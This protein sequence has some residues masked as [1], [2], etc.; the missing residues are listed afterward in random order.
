MKLGDIYISKT[1]KDIIQIDSFATP[2]NDEGDMYIIIACIFNNGGIYGSSPSFNQYATQKEIEDR[3]ELLV[4]RED[5]DKFDD[6]QE[7]FK[8]VETK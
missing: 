3:F 2:L 5:L 6:W 7:V 8:L 4:D 1:T